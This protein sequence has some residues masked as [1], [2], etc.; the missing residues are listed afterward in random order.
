MT[1]P[2]RI[3]TD[4]FPAGELPDEL[5]GNIDPGHR[6]RITVEDMNGVAS[7]SSTPRY[8]RYA[9]FASQKNTSMADA[10]ERIR[11]LRDEWD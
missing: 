6:V 7:A 5:R 2:R 11:S 8:K 10:V 4:D 1:L 3:V 9:G